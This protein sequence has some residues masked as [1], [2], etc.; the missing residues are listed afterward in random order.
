[1]V[2]KMGDKVQLNKISGDIKSYFIEINSDIKIENIYLTQR[3]NRLII[4]T[5]DKLVIKDMLGEINKVTII[6]FNT[7][8][9]ILKAEVISNT[10]DLV[11]LKTNGE[12]IYCCLGGDNYE[13][14]KCDNKFKNFILNKNVLC[15]LSIDQI[16]LCVFSLNNFN[17]FKFK[18][19]LLKINVSKCSY[20]R[21]SENNDYLV[22]FEKPKFLTMY[23]LSDGEKI[24]FTALYS[25]INNLLVSNE[26]VYLAMR[27]R[28][29]LSL[30]I[31][32]PK[33]PFH[34]LRIKKLPSR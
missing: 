6:D 29:I 32:D 30:L 34:D 22:Y 21:L 33:E 31:V 28:R 7:H 3:K 9:S 5:N 18:N 13:L 12:L 14:I 2:H 27:D 10:D 20:Y 15:A 1:M 24:A 25:D 8:D 26:Y 16:E 17:V 4:F 11:I 23:R 19:L